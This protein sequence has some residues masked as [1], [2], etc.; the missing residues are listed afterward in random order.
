M[1]SSW[2]FIFNLI[3]IGAAGQRGSNW[4]VGTTPPADLTTAL[5]NALQYDMYLYQTGMEIY[6][7]DGT[8]WVYE[9]SILGKGVAGSQGAN[10]ATGQ[11]GATWTAQ[12]TAPTTNIL[13]GDYWLRT[14]DNGVF[15]YQDTSVGTIVSANWNWVTNLGTVI[16]SGTVINN[17][18]T[19]NNT[20]VSTLNPTFV[21]GQETFSTET[22]VIA[23]G[24]SMSNNGS[25]TTLSSAATVSGGGVQYN[26]GLNIV[27]TT[28]GVGTVSSTTLGTEG[29]LILNDFVP[30]EILYGSTVASYNGRALL[31]KSSIGEHLGFNYDTTNSHVVLV[32]G[33]DNSILTSTTLGP[34]ESF[35]SGDFLFVTQ[36]GGYIPSDGSTWPGGIVT[37]PTLVGKIGVTGQTLYSGGY[38]YYAVTQDA[39]DLFSTPGAL[40]SSGSVPATTNIL[41]YAQ[42][43]LTL[44]SQIGNLIEPYI[45]ISPQAITFASTSSGGGLLEAF[46]ASNSTLSVNIAEY[47]TLSGFSSTVGYIEADTNTLSIGWPE[48]TIA[49][50]PVGTSTG[51]I[52]I[53][54]TGDVTFQNTGNV[55]FKN[56]GTV[57]GVNATPIPLTLN[58][59]VTSGL[60]ALVITTGATASSASFTNGTLTLNL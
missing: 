60:Q 33:F 44:S 4:T 19:V 30:S 16:N 36:E 2:Q 15:Q 27:I 10:G 13:V 3:G 45:T 23:G 25:L 9:G 12:V 31:Q 46:V 38:I 52:I 7:F 21:Y 54:G 17:Y 28:N 6:Q 34:A 8:E 35:S 47:D 18:P 26:P 11:R 51:N 43:G 41:H 20:I 39:I 24:L 40:V 55:E 1:N 32:S 57:S 50:T 58:G 56:G 59:S 22:L 5:P 48:I 14:T 42:S 37:T 29:Y 49:S 53:G